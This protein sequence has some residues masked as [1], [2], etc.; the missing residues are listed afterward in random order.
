MLKSI[1]SYVNLQYSGEKATPGSTLANAFSESD[2]AVH[3]AV[4]SNIY[5]STNTLTTHVQFVY[6]LRW[7]LETH[8]SR[9]RSLRIARHAT[10]NK[11][12]RQYTQL[13]ARAVVVYER[14][15]RRE[16]T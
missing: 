16:F 9:S 14:G 11:T 3:C 5:T 13:G 6:S 12:S 4:H 8:N 10:E 1:V 7:L 2:N 15:A